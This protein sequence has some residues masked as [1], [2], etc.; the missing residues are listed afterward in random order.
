MQSAFVDCTNKNTAGML[1]N[2]V[3]QHPEWTNNFEPF[4]KVSN[5][6]F[7]GDG[8]GLQQCRWV[9]FNLPHSHQFSLRPSKNFSSVYSKIWA[10]NLDQQIDQ[11]M[12]DRSPNKNL[13]MKLLS[14]RL[15][16]D[17]HRK[18]PHGSSSWVKMQSQD[19]PLNYAFSFRVR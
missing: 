4:K 10:S 12:F 7:F 2:C 1:D 18:H 6:K 8:D 13:K 16:F 5:K 14:V 17:G 3:S 15:P 11:R 19:Y 9:P